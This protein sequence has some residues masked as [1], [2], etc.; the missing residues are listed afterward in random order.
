MNP[1]DNT[2]VRVMLDDFNDTGVQ[3]L[4]QNRGRAR[5]LI[6]TAKQMAHKIGMHGVISVPWKQS[7]GVTWMGNGSPGVAFVYG[8]EHP[9]KRWRNGEEGDAGSYRDQENYIV[10]KKDRVYLKTK[11]PVTI[12]SDEDVTIN[13]GNGSKKIILNGEVHAG[14]AGGVLAAQCG[15]ACATKVYVV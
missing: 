1:S 12:E 7:V 2:H 8:L 13:A 9:D 11:F 5:E 15:G 6:G 10:F 4:V 3:Q 14:G